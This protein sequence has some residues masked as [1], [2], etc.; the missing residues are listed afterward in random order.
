MGEKMSTLCRASFVL[1][2]ALA[3]WVS[4]SLAAE[5]SAPSETGGIMQPPSDPEKAVLLEFQEMERRGPPEAYELFME[6]HPDH[7]LAAEASRRLQ[8]MRGKKPASPDGD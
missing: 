1:V 7:P 2:V 6:R 3:F 8:E 4:P 5:T